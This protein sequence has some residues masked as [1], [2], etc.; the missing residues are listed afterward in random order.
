MRLTCGVVYST[1]VF[2]FFCVINLNLFCTFQC[3]YFLGPASVEE[4]LLN[5]SPQHQSADASQGSW[6]VV[7]P[8]AKKHE[9]ASLEFYNQLNLIKLH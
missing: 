2:I 7:K 4:L 3:L 9:Q 5:T 1:C 6:Q 8:N